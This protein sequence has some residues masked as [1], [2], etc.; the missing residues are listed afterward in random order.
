MKKTLSYLFMLLLMAACTKEEEMGAPVASELHE[1]G[2]L[3]LVE[4]RTEEIFIISPK[5]QSL[6]SIMTLEELSNYLSDLLTIGDR[7]GVY[8]FENYSIAYI[9]L[10]QLRDDDIHFDSSTKSIQLTLPAI[11]IEP[12]GRS[13]NIRKLHE[14]VSGLQG[15]I[16]SEERRQMQNEASQLAI[17]ALAPGTPKH[18]EL[19]E[20]A[21]QKARA[22]FTGM[23]H[24]RGCK[25]VTITFKS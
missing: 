9:D 14:R 13:G 18:K 11:Q 5:E 21:E 12:I 10:T 16:K 24:A 1:V 8:S 3:E 6:K 15:S 22:F 20:Q 2:K 7:V 25:E 4:Y 19:V 17:K 23:L